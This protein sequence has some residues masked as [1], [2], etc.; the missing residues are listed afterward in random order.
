MLQ[1]QAVLEALTKSE[2]RKSLRKLSASLGQAFEDTISRIGNEP[3]NRRQVAL[4]SLTWVSRARRPLQINELR[5]ALATEIGDIRF[6]QD[7]L[8]QA[9]FI[10]E[11]C[12]GLV[13][14][15][16]ESLTVRLVHHTLQD[17]LQSRYQHQI[18]EEETQI[19]AICLTYLCF[20]EINISDVGYDFITCGHLW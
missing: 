18:S 6:D 11:S 5:H 9:K 19:T 10:V 3:P 20:D 13:I 8:L 1:I 15:D 7:N 17:Y 12:S 4:R 2:I 16:D 14:I